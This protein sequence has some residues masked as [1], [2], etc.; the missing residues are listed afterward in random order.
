MR[1]QKIIN[2]IESS[3]TWKI[4]KTYITMGDELV[5]NLS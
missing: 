1:L 5:D 4:R 2:Q 3:L